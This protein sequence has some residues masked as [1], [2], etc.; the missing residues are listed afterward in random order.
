MASC[1]AA[2]MM[3]AFHGTLEQSNAMSKNPVLRLV[4]TGAFITI[5]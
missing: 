5:K 1:C 4:C 2:P 3:V